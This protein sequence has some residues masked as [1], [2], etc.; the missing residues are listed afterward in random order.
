MWV[1]AKGNPF[2][3]KAVSRL[4]GGEGELVSVETYRNWR[5]DRP[6]GSNAFVFHALP[7][8]RKVQANA[9]RQRTHG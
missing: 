4:S 5:M 6:T 7:G 8:A 2:V 3:L 1:A 9:P